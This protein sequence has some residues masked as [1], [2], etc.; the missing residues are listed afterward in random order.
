ML[1]FSQSVVTLPPFRLGTLGQNIEL[2]VEDGYI[3][4]MMTSEDYLDQI[5]Q[6]PCSSIYQVSC[7][8]NPIVVYNTKVH[9]VIITIKD[10]Q[11]T[12]CYLNSRP[13][14]I[15]RLCLTT[16]SDINEFLKDLHDHCPQAEFPQE[17]MR[18][19]QT[20][21]EILVQGM[22]SSPVSE[23]HGKSS[24]QNGSQHTESDLIPYQDED[25]G[26]QLQIVSQHS[27]ADENGFSEAIDRLDTYQQRTNEKSAADDLTLHGNGDIM[28]I[29]EPP[30]LPADQE[31]VPPDEAVEPE[32]E[33]TSPTGPELISRQKGESRP[34]TAQSMSITGE[35]LT[36]KAD[37]AADS[38]AK[39]DVSA[40]MNNE[41]DTPMPCTHS[42]PSQGK[43]SQPSRTVDRIANKP[44]RNYLVKPKIPIAASKAKGE[45]H[46]PAIS[47]KATTVIRDERG[48]DKVTT[49]SKTTNIYD[50]PADEDDQ[51]TPKKV[52]QPTKGKKSKVFRSQQKGKANSKSKGKNGKPCPEPKRTP[53]EVDQ[54]IVPKRGSQRAAANQAKISMSKIDDDSDEDIEE[55]LSNIEEIAPTL[56]NVSRKRKLV[57]QPVDFDT[58]ALK[59]ITSLEPVLEKAESVF[60]LQQQDTQDS[61]LVG[62]NFPPDDPFQ[63]DDLS[64]VSPSASR[65]QQDHSEGKP[66][67]SSRRTAA[68]NFAIQLDDLLSDDVV[69]DNKMAHTK[70]FKKGLFKKGEP[71]VASPPKLGKLKEGNS[72]KK[73][74]LIEKEPLEEQSH[75][76]PD[77]TSHHS[78]DCD[79]QGPRSMKDDSFKYEV[80]QTEEW[81]A[82]FAP[83]RE[84]Q[85]NHKVRKIDHVEDRLNTTPVTSGAEKEMDKSVHVTQACP[86]V[87]AH[88]HS[89][90]R[91][92]KGS[93]QEA[94]HKSATAD[95]M[96]S[97]VHRT[98]PEETAPTSPKPDVMVTEEKKRKVEAEVSLPSKRHRPTPTKSSVDSSISRPAPRQ[99]VKTFPESSAGKNKGLLD[100]RKIRKPNLIHFGSKGAENQGSSGRSKP[101]VE[102]DAESHTTPSNMAKGKPKHAAR[103]KRR[104]VSDEQ[105][106]EGLFVSQSPPK[107]RQS[108]SPPDL[109]SPK[110][111]SMMTHGESGFMAPAILRSSS[112]RSRVTGLGSPLAQQ[113]IPSIGQRLKAKQTAPAPAFG[114]LEPRTL[115]SQQDV[116]TIA[117]E[118]PDN[119]A[120]ETP[121]IFGPRIKVV[122][123]A[124]A[125]PA[126][127]E[128]SPIR[129]VA[130]TKTQD[131]KYE[132]ISTMQNIQEEKALP[133]PFIE[134]IQPKSSGF[135]KRLRA[136][137]AGSR[138]KADRNLN[139]PLSD[140]D[141]TL[142]EV[143]RTTRELSSPGEMTSSSSFRSDDFSSTPTQELSPTHHWALAIR[144]HYKGYADTV[145]KIADVSLTLEYA[146]SLKDTDS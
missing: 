28:N 38:S 45:S 132:D 72:A 133:D 121:E 113:D 58:P 15:Q 117:V 131:G 25:F 82:V 53:T 70:I 105:D 24:E 57:E 12:F 84:S 118:S 101:V 107:K 39:S 8:K 67:G 108:L 116:P 34:G 143:Q 114:Q 52:S 2:V 61:G 94:V 42:S 142:V 17:V 146:F 9:D 49:S 3:L 36:A 71:P 35:M 18:A 29:S 135:T 77:D 13:T 96:I 14:T 93:Q 76:S 99:H 27:R 127:P 56:P 47:A 43:Q 122:S 85:E 73:S 30:Q 103:S 119:D 41:G 33:D 87:E 4:L 11:E 5:L 106:E 102:R 7:T 145:H 10:D 32:V 97:N 91:F 68:M 63:P 89:S 88:S 80:R 138:S 51:I 137:Q 112:Q 130:H 19:S 144:P 86:V 78:G 37:V 20:Q 126:A 90:T 69:G 75:G 31:T 123:I 134:D 125:R 139:V 64:I 136:R 92:S 40:L 65:Q 83:K 115:I 21:D 54:P 104:H 111:A 110:I 109:G 81:T 50:F 128:A 120:N 124:K 62:N 48:S 95:T 140:P 16:D 6:V 129:Y 23:C 98:D 74:T 55:D 66:D 22:G 79:T 60:D 46:L 1:Y 100:D 141:K 26:S 44:Q 59:S